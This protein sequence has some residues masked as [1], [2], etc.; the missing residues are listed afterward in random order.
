MIERLG[1]VSIPVADQDR[2]KSF[3]VEQL[4]F[5]CLAD[6]HFAEGMRWVTVAPT[7]AETILSLVT[8]L[9]NMK[10]GSL[11]GLIFVVDDIDAEYARLVAN[12]VAFDGEPYTE[13]FGKFAKFRDPDG[14]RLTLREL[15]K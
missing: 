4:G 3:Y 11:G 15:L 10:P 2:A 8:W 14:N 13:Q 9:E 1:I 7:G 12:G 5:Q 6:V